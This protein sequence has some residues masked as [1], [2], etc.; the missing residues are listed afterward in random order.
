MLR[1]RNKRRFRLSG[2]AI[3]FFLKMLRRDIQLEAH[4][5]GRD[6]KRHVTDRV[7]DELEGMCLGKKGFVICVVD[8][9]EDS[10]QAGLIDNDTGAVNVTVWCQTIVFRP[11]N[12]EVVDAVVTIANDE[13]GFFAK[14][15]PLEVFVSRHN[16]PGD[17]SFDL[18]KGD[19][20]VSD[21]GE[22]EI[23]EGS[24]VRLRIMGL[25]VSADTMSAIG[26]IQEDYLG[27][28]H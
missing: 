26:T 24:V 20:W 25:T 5:L 2:A 21:D 12:N 27:F 14:V 18:T 3:M 15:G 11:F 19:S 17:I 7:M 13:T 9:N 10:I 23:T 8:I 16:M 4:L 6:M 28:L 22:I 1:L